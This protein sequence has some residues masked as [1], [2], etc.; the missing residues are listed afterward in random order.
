VRNM[1]LTL[2]RERGL[3][4]LKESDKQAKRAGD[5]FAKKERVSLKLY[6]ELLVDEIVGGDRFGPEGDLTARVDYIF[7]R[8]NETTLHRTRL[9][10]FI[11]QTQGTG[12]LFGEWLTRINAFNYR[13]FG[14]VLNE[15]LEK[16]GSEVRLR[17]ESETIAETEPEWLRSHRSSSV[18]SL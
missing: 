11:Y 16:R 17:F 9:P 14:E 10:S 7:K 8:G 1:K 2:L 18:R 5:N 13:M 12:T 3:A 15:V 6:A 4:M